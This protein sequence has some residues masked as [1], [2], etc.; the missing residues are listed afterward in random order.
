MLRQDAGQSQS[1]AGYRKAKVEVIANPGTK[2]EVVDWEYHARFEQGGGSNNKDVMKFDKGS[3]AHQIEF[4]L[5]DNTGFDLSFYDDPSEAM[6]VVQGTHCPTAAGDGD[7]EIQ[8]VDV[9][10]GRLTVINLNNVA[11]DLCYALR[12]NGQPQL[13]VPPYLYDPIIK[14]GGGG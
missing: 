5:T 9:K 12:F 1:M 7:G 4:S 13:L 14:N 3:G 11:G 8:F 10:N 6:W 2:G